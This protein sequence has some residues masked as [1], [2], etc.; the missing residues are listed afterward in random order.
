MIAIR[1]VVT[2]ILSL[3]IASSWG[4]EVLELE[5]NTFEVT[6]T[7]FNYLALLFYDESDK[8]KKLESIWKK[9]AALLDDTM[10]ANSQMGQVRCALLTSLLTT[11]I[12]MQILGS[13]PDL[14]EIIDAYGIS[15]PSII[16]FRKGA[17]TDYRGPY[18]S[19]GMA[20]YIAEDVKVQSKYLCFKFAAYCNMHFIALY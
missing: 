9:A 10:P 1:A 4:H 20:E 19:Q 7:A 8:G 6:L 18:L 17:P 11:H 12:L 13:D 14:K 2:C 5:S 3:L 16:V 15:V